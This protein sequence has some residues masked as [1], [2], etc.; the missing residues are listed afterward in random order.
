MG[1]F[2][3]TFPKNFAGWTSEHA[4]PAIL[5][6]GAGCKFSW[7]I[8]KPHQN[9]GMQLKRSLV[10]WIGKGVGIGQAKMIKHADFA[11]EWRG[12]D[13]TRNQTLANWDWTPPFGKPIKPCHGYL[14]RQPHLPARLP[15]GSPVFI[16][17]LVKFDDISKNP[18]FSIRL[19][20]GNHDNHVFSHSPQ[21][22]SWLSMI[23]NVFP[24]LFLRFSFDEPTNSKLVGFGRWSN[25][26]WDWADHLGHP[27]VDYCTIV[28]HI[29]MGLLMIMGVLWI[30]YI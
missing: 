15:M 18:E 30:I 22:F 16:I 21:I 6:C 26:A 19:A 3:A 9:G 11:V 2:H 23:S 25:G 7:T 12:F 4:P 20:D 28:F 5:I 24:T 1:M 10:W 17:L 8:L 27:G 29:S 14:Q 13:Q